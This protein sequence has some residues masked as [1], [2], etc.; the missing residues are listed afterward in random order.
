MAQLL[1]YVGGDYLPAKLRKKADKILL[2]C[3]LRG[4]SGAAV[5]LKEIMLLAFYKNPTNKLLQEWLSK[6]STITLKKLANLKYNIDLIEHFNHMS[7]LDSI[8]ARLQ[9]DPNPN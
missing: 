2:I 7:Q 6:G 9:N 5:M 4:Q 3:E 1:R 8:I